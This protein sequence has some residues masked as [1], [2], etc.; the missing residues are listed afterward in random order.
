MESR[1]A[2][3]FGALLLIGASFVSLAGAQELPEPDPEEP[4]VPSE[5]AFS[6]GDAYFEDFQADD[7]GW[8]SSAPSGAIGWEWGHPE[9][10]SYG[11]DVGDDENLWG[12]N[13]AGD[14]SEGEC[15]WIE[16]PAIDLTTPEATVANVATLTWDNF[17]RATYLES[18]GVVQI[19]VGG[20]YTNIVPEDGYPGS[21]PT[22]EVD[23][24]LEHETQGS[25]G[26]GSFPSSP[27]DPLEPMSADISE[28]LGEEI[29][30]RF[31]FAS[32]DD[33]YG[34]QDGWF[35]DNVAVE[36]EFNQDLPE[37]AVDPGLQNP[38]WSADGDWEYGVPAEEGPVGEL[39]YATGVD[40]EYTGDTCSVLETAID[41]PVEGGQLSWDQWLRSS[42][43]SAGGTIQVV[44]DEGV[45]NI[46][47]E[48]GYVDDPWSLDTDECTQHESQDTGV[49]NGFEQSSGDRMETFTADLSD[50][51]GEQVTLRFAWGVEDTSFT[52]Y[53][54]WHIN[55][56]TLDGTPL[57]PASPVDMGFLNDVPDPEEIDPVEIVQEV[58][59]TVNATLEQL[60][61]TSEQYEGW[62][63]GGEHISWAYDEATTGPVGENVT[64]TN[65]H[66]V[67]SEDEYECSYVQSPTIPTAAAGE[68]PELSLDHQVDMSYYDGWFS[69]G[70]RTAG[71]ILVSTDAGSSWEILETEANDKEIYYT[72]IYDCFE[73]LGVQPDGDDN[74]APVD[75]A[76]VIGG[77]NG[78]METLDVALDEY[79]NATSL[80]FRFAFGTGT[81]V[82]A[83]GGW[84]FN[85]VSLGDV[86]LME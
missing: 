49:M 34:T 58:Q 68:D 26:F 37:Q 80:T 45:H 16:S 5:I 24:C 14:F 59:D 43:F 22:S 19:G 42:S 65:P 15:S 60:L 73:E 70:A 18:G 72:G 33:P 12:T 27:N 64:A 46:V 6:L 79:E 25:G 17:F 52:S 84:Y 50:W 40:A 32:T 54:G 44:D 30:V 28:F 69:S 48:E 57:L 51:S 86:Q 3:L 76:G 74:R 21:D 53:P 9:E 23:D 11:P 62:T 38:L 75:A 7:G 41:V 77:E 55:N 85:N 83:Q 39:V 1:I 63:V 66:G 67:H 36:L 29:T 2:T 31:L 71:L 56:V 47:P 35:I 13:L 82:Y 8:D 20:D 81:T 61:A 10:T 78:A 4:A